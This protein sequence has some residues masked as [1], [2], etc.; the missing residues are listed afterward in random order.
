MMMVS[1]R[2]GKRDGEGNGV[3][4]KLEKMDD[5]VK[6]DFIVSVQKKHRFLHSGESR[7]RSAPGLTMAIKDLSVVRLL[8]VSNK[9]IKRKHDLWKIDWRKTELALFYPRIPSLSNL[10]KNTVKQMD[11]RLLKVALSTLVQVE[12]HELAFSMQDMPYYIID[13]LSGVKDP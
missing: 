5:D 4:L 3:F 1:S 12:R 13:T 7:A 11:L 9:W 8:Q 10:V 2:A 6:A